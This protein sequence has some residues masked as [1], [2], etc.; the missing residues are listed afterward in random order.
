MNPIKLNIIPFLVISALSLAFSLPVYGAS[1]LELSFEDEIKPLLARHC[2]ECHGNNDE[3]RKADLNLEYFQTVASLE[4]VPDLLDDALFYVEEGDM[5]PK[6]YQHQL[7]GTDQEHLIQWLTRT[8]DRIESAAKNDP[9][10][11]VAQRLNHLEYD[12]VVSDLTDVEIR[13]ARFFPRDSGSG[14]GFTNVGADQQ[15]SV[16]YLEK[17]LDAARFVSSHARITALRGIRWFPEPQ[18]SAANTEA[19]L[20]SL[21]GDWALWH[22]EQE[23]LQSANDAETHARYL[24]AAWQYDNRAAFGHPNVELDALAAALSPPLYPSVLETYHDFLTRDPQTFVD[25]NDERLA[26]LVR[27][28]QALPEL[29][30]PG[31]TSEDIKERAAAIAETFFG[32]RDSR[33]K[34]RELTRGARS[35]FSGNFYTPFTDYGDFEI[36]VISTDEMQRPP[37]KPRKDPGPFYLSADDM[38]RNA[39]PDDIAELDLLVAEVGK[40][41]NP[42]LKNEANLAREIIADLAPKAWRR[43]VNDAEIDALLVPYL[44]GREN[45]ETLDA[46]VK[47]S[48]TALLISPEFIFRFRVDA[49]EGEVVAL[50]PTEL[51]SRLSFALWG[52]LPD[53]ELR[54]VSFNGTLTQEAIYRQQIERHLADANLRF[55]VE[56]FAAQWLHF[57]T[58]AESASPDPM[59][60]PDFS[61]ALAADMEESLKRFFQNVFLENKPITTLIDAREMPMSNRMAAYYGLVET[62]EFKGRKAD[63]SRAR[64]KDEWHMQTLPSEFAGILSSGPVTIGHSQPLRTSP[65]KRG[66][67]VVQELLGT[68]MPPPPAG[69]PQLSEDEVSAEG[70]TLAEQMAIHRKDPACISCHVK[71]DPVGLA[72]E[73][74]DPAGR[75]RTKDAAGNPLITSGVSPEGYEINGLQGLANYLAK[76][77]NVQAIARQY[78]H[79]LVGYLLGRQVE[80]G[81]RELI[82]S[83][84]ESMSE[85]DWRVLPALRLA[86]ISP[87]FLQKRNQPQS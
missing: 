79:K 3:S 17:W 30:A 87:Q 39:S 35:D 2:Y 81:D 73:N 85:N 53:E 10:Q 70:L 56:Q 23:A 58:F 61:P 28:W 76:E 34:L 27:T 54:E 46:A 6:E 63:L 64:W 44:R 11:V 77:K 68:P 37:N 8:L 60:F 18:S 25:S 20:A 78:S 62:P 7:V 57:N 9:G 49:P 50:T 80:I 47:D 72:F 36:S 71:L 21:A 83:M 51:A 41:L 14:E 29:G 65:I 24:L 52:T 86:L 4:S 19:L 15:S 55:L 66:A 67:W 59:K 31:G 5:P 74:I 32:D 1:N 38:R 12:L 33:S 84:V 43:P 82:D 40:A 42:N 22:A 16:V 26:E 75:W 13:A 69:I 48:I 45:G